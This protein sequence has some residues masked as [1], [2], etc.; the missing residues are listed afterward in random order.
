M[1]KLKFGSKSFK[2]NHYDLLR[3]RGQ[4]TIREMPNIDNDMF[5]IIMQ[6]FL[7]FI[8][9]NFIYVWIYITNIFKVLKDSQNLK[10]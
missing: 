2:L 3:D 5:A 4:S 7:G 10:V 6:L 1:K 8:T 9:I